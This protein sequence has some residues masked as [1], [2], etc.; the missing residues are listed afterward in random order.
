MVLTLSTQA[1]VVPPWVVEHPDV[2]SDPN[3]SITQM[4]TTN[5]EA[6]SM[7]LSAPLPEPPPQPYQQ[8][9]Q[10]QH[11]KA[12]DG[13]KGG[14]GGKGG[15]IAEGVRAQKSSGT[16]S[17]TSLLPQSSL[18]YYCSLS[19]SLP[20]SLSPSLSLSLS[21]PLSVLA[22][23][24]PLSLL[25]PTSDAAYIPDDPQLAETHYSQVVYNII[26]IP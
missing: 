13:G 9:Q 23:S 12:G 26:I 19:P 24:L 5:S 8:Q 3:F 21:L 2:F 6:S 16:L 10:Q 7:E 17:L 1:R 4:D 22:P 14:K 20:L 15:G 25:A 11:V 18:Q